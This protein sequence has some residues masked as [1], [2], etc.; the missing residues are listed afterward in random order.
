MTITKGMVLPRRCPHARGGE[1]DIIH[2][3]EVL[4]AVVP[5]HV[6]VNRSIRPRCTTRR[7]CPH[8]RGGEPI[9][10]GGSIRFEVVVPT[11]VGVNRSTR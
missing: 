11:H 3:F 6:G 5:T 7:G 1:P 9:P 10:S 2:G 4:E 8:A